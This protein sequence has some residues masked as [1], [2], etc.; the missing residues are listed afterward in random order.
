MRV[1]LDECLPRRLR[2]ELAG[3]EVYTVPEMGWAGI[4][5]GELLRLAAPQFDVFLTVDKSLEHQQN[6]GAVDIGVITLRARRNDIQAL[7]PLMPAVGDVLLKVTPG[8]VVS[9]SD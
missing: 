4:D 6:I 1:L 5:N 2:H 9:V 3:H 7:L 8:S